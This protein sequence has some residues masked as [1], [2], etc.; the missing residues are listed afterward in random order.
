[1]VYEIASEKLFHGFLYFLLF[2]CHHNK[3]TD[4]GKS[5]LVMSFDVGKTNISCRKGRH[6]GKRCC[7]C[8][9]HRLHLSVEENDG[10]R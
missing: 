7:H 9:V 3:D 10:G 2:R 6:F 8:M 1:M 4:Y 5:R